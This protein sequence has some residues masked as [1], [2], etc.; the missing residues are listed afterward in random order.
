MF[1]ENVM[2]PTE[3]MSQHEV[4]RFLHQA[5]EEFLSL[6]KRAEIDSEPGDHLGYSKN[7]PFTS[8]PQAI[9]RV[10]TPDESSLTILAVDTL[11]YP[12]RKQ[13]RE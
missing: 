11:A 1:G 6:V 12:D 13:Y 4:A 8:S 7:V 5:F 2:G 3:L 9:G 10:T